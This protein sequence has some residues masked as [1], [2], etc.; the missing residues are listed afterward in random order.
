VPV[1]DR[2]GT[3]AVVDDEEAVL[4]VAR[5]AL[6]LA[7][8]RVLTATN[9]VEAAELARRDDGALSLMLLDLA[10]PVMG[11]IEAIRQTTPDLPIAVMTGLATGQPC[12]G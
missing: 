11:G 2:G 12:T 7:G 10:T 6:E 3:I 1:P 4:Y 8:Y 9:G 5:G